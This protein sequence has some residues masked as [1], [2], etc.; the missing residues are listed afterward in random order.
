MEEPVGVTGWR[1][2][3]RRGARVVRDG[4][5]VLWSPAAPLDLR[6]LGKTLLHA[7]L[8]GTIAGL[9]GAAFFAGLEVA[10]RLLLKG[11]A[12][13]EPLRARGET[14][15]GAAAAHPLRPWLLALLPAL[16]GLASGLLTW[17][18]APEAA[19]GG[20]DATIEAY[21]HGGAVIRRRV[22]L[23]KALAAIFSLASGGAGGRE[24]PTMHIGGAVGSLVGRWLPTSARERRLLLVAGVAAGM[25]AVFRTPLGAALLAVEMLYRDDFESDALVPAILASVI[26]YSIVIAI[27]G[28]TTLFGR[29][30][31]FPFVPAHVPLYALLA[32]V[33][34]LMG[35]AFISV[36]RR[37][38][39][40]SAKLPLP[41]WAR[42]A[43]GGLLMGSFGTLLVLWL[44][45]WNRGPGPGLG[46][47]GGGYG[48]AQLAITGGDG[49]PV[50]GRLVALFLLLCLAKLVAA[51]L[52]IGSGGA[53]GDF[54]PSLVIG[55]LLGG[56]FGQGLA[57][58]LHDP[59]IQPGAFALVGMGTFYGG[60]AH[61][62]LSALV[63]VAELAGSYDLLVPMMLATG[64]AFVLLRHW[65]LYP[66]Q[67]PTQR[68][69]PA[70]RA[71]EP[72]PEMRRIH[73][74]KVM[75]AP[76]VEGFAAA[77]PFAE[78]VRRTSQA[79]RQFV[80]AVLGKDG[81][82][83]GLV[84][85]DLLRVIAPDSGLE[86]AIAADLM[87]PFVSVSPKATLPEVVGSLSSN[88]IRQVPVMEGDRILGFV[89]EA[90]VARAFLVAIER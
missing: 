37:V 35:V 18:F 12:G 80:F 75:V 13:Y 36:L 79:R 6:I 83:V 47:F 76:E 84:D 8:V 61:A 29:L 33:V 59:T 2:F 16:G 77:T 70:H 34:S 64:I 27:F 20:G 90:E 28:E 24:G 57:L 54:A 55:G 14:F 51:S 21:H 4:L 72:P 53:A 49:L 85:F 40:T 89:G 7:A 63:M 15:L 9:I 38:Q 42:P 22:I 68:D 88:G 25:S 81:A 73:A 32:V 11:L 48:A 1:S 44:G 45:S 30:P 78:V 19:G 69:S 39:K 87:G 26:A 46:V 66:A 82:P 17:R 60:I 50:G 86:W 52:T 62:P 3:P 41:V 74:G 67:L 43:L 58:V 10:Q 56:A 23:V 31:R 65:S 5:A 71:G